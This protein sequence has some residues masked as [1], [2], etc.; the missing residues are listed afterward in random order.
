MTYLLIPVRGDLYRL[1]V[2][3]ANERPML[4]TWSRMETMTTVLWRRP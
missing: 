3:Y 1:A 4:W 2:W